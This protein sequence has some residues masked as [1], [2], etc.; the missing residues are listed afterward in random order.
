MKVTKQL[1]IK[2][3]STKKNSEDKIQKFFSKTFGVLEKACIFA[4]LF[5]R[6]GCSCLKEQKLVERLNTIKDADVA[7][8]ARAADL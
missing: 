6:K 4:V 1:K 3:L 2:L 8:L 5:N 7:Q